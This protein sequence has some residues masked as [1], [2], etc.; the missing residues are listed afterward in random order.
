M[1]PTLYLLVRLSLQTGTCDSSQEVLGKAV[2]IAERLAAAV[3]VSAIRQALKKSL[4][5]S[6]TAQ[7]AKV[8]WGC[9]LDSIN[10]RRMFLPTQQKNGVIW[11]LC[12]WHSHNP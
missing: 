9:Q 12:V 3:A 4:V 1:N 10:V 11:E 7:F 8:A 6:I 5:S 2:W